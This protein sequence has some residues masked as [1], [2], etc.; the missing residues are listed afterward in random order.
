MQDHMNK[1]KG[2]HG[3]G[4]LQFSLS[5]GLLVW[6]TNK[7]IKTMFLGFNH[8]L[9]TTKTRLAH[10]VCSYFLSTSFCLPNQSLG[11]I[12][13]LRVSCVWIHVFLF[14]S[15]WLQDKKIKIHLLF[16][17]LLCFRTMYVF[18]VSLCINSQVELLNEMNQR[19]QIHAKLS[20]I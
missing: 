10:D 1:A 16:D 9:C 5:D 14:L 19:I 6:R 12:I 7:L 2:S 17:K 15:F 3:G 4:E 20:L 8:H 18:F 11:G 13:Q